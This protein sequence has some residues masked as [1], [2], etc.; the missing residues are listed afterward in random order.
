MI[1]LSHFCSFWGKLQ[2]SLGNMGKPSNFQLLFHSMDIVNREKFEIEVFY[3]QFQKFT[4][5]AKNA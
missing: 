2:N 4:K 5:N 1:T 3:R